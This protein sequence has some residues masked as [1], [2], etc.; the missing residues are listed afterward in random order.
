MR[1]DEIKKGP[2]RVAHRSLL[3]CMGMDTEDFKKPIIGIANGYTDFIPGHVHLNQLVEQIKLGVAQ[4]GGVTR[5]FGIIGVCDGLVMGHTGMRYSL[6]SRELICDTIELMTR[7]H[8]LD[9]LI[10]VT[11]CDKI[12]P[13][14]IMAAARL[15]IPAIV[16]SGGAMLAGRL[17][18]QAIDLAGG[19][20]VAGK[21]ANGQISEQDAETFEKT[22]CPTPGSCSGLYTANSMNCLMEPLGIALPGN[23]TIPAPYGARLTLAK[24]AGRRVVDLVK[25]DV[26]PL[27]IMTR[28]AMLNAIT[29]DM[30]IGGST[31]TVLHLMAVA[32][33]AGVELSLDDFDRISR[34]TPN[35]CRLSPAGQ[36]HIE[37][38]NDAGGIP[39]VM[40][41]LASRDLLDLSAKT[42]A[43]GTMADVVAAAENFDPNVIHHIDAPYAQ[44][45]GLRILRGNLAPEGSVIK[46]AALGGDFTTFK[47]KAR[48]FE[49]EEE[50]G[51][52]VFANKVKAGDVI[53]IRNEGP[54]G[55]PGFR[56]M[57]VVTAALSGMGLGDKVMLLTDGRF[58]GASRGAAI[59]HVAPEAAVGGPIAAV[60]DGDEIEL[61]L[62]KRELNLL[63]DP[64]EIA[65]RAAAYQPVD[66]G[67]PPGG[68]LERYA[69]L[70]GQASQGAVYTKK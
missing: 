7:A 69:Q 10:M 23:G 33:S 37:D 41:E 20:E 64:A 55:G 40:K 30:A 65:K 68:Y 19:F 46:V 29:V 15:N 18:N 50:A 59:G 45:G 58:S 4:A 21:L 63:L 5:E 60:R 44:E 61:D 17:R 9:G 42:V 52:F 67:L 28:T 48:V 3:R 66:K 25:E 57:L 53:V 14:C 8:C 26:R 2:Q 39:A 35:L 1:S 11:N 38:L 43:G 34:N 70:V 32:N 22:C 12:D 6:P 31:N 16:V 54:V 24:A 62:T 49:S 51:E 13:A 56:E 47:G 27:E 36:H